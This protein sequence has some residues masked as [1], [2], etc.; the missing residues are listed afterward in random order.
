[1]QATSCCA[2]AARLRY[3]RRYFNGATLLR[4]ERVADLGQ[5]VDI[6]AGGNQQV[7][8]SH[9]P[10]LCGNMNCG[11]SHLRVELI[12]IVAALYE[13]FHLRVVAFASAFH[14]QAVFGLHTTRVGVS[15]NR[16]LRNTGTF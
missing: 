2:Y 7:S 11:V 6:G 5:D 8:D 4:A 3:A 14:E 12:H 9:L 13:P 16:R 15:A 1:V 10:V